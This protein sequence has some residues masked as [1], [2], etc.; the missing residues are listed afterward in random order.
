MNFNVVGHSLIDFRSTLQQ[1][2]NTVCTT[3]YFLVEHQRRISIIIWKNYLNTSPF[4]NYYPY[5]DRF[6][7]AFISTKLIYYN[8][9]NIE[10]DVKIQLSSI[11]PHIKDLQKSETM[12]LFSLN[13]SV[14]FTHSVTSD[15]LQPHGLQH[16]RLPCPSPMPRAYLNSC[17]SSR[18]CH[19]TTSSS[20]IPFSSCL[21]SSPASGSF[22]ISQFF[23][24]GGQSI[25]VSASASVLPM[26][27]QEWFPLG[28]TGWISL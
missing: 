4:S 26:N 18:W 6:F 28:W 8:R 21:Q 23:S 13:P 5:E 20:A 9:L 27:I 1:I 25:G 3:C 11:K 14:Q 16:T 19:P 10:A 17:P 2:F 15:S 7:F 12:L 22:P 24:S